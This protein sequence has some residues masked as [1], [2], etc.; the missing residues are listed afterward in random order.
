MNLCSFLRLTI[1][2][3]IKADIKH[4]ENKEDIT[5]QVAV[6]IDAGVYY[7]VDKAQ[8]DEDITTLEEELARS[9]KKPYL[10]GQLIKNPKLASIYLP[11][12]LNLNASQTSI[13]VGFTPLRAIFRALMIMPVNEAIRKKYTI[14]VSALLFTVSTILE[15]AAKSYAII[16]P[17]QIIL[18]SA[19]GL[20]SG[21]IPTYIAKNYAIKWRGRL[22]ALYQ[23]MVAFRVMYGYITAAIFTRV[24]GNWR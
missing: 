4:T 9:S 8:I 5:N 2:K 16:L 22:V 20:T 23:C 1:S 3:L 15:A 18:S 11:S 12:D 14:I 19:L 10:L 21:T 17:S 6:K 7:E 13:V 24:E